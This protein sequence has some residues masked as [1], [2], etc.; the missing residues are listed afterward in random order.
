MLG[1]HWWN[2]WDSYPDE[3]EGERIALDVVKKHLG[4]DVKP[5][6]I[7]VGLNRE[8]IPQY[9]VGHDERIENAGEVLK[10]MFKGNLLVA[11]S[12]YE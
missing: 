8:C 2:G 11:G 4:I 12:S 5:D 3:E 7:H 1:G 9:T 6:K 10:D